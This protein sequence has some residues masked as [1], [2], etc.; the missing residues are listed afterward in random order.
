MTDI[1]KCTGEKGKEICKQR[2][3]CY[4]YTAPD[5]QHWQSYFVEVPA[6]MNT[7]SNC[8]MFM[9]RENELLHTKA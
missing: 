6:T 3:K 8:E 4:R 7:T 2:E 5:N 1:T 9:E